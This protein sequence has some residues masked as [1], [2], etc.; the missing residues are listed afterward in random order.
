MRGFQILQLILNGWGYFMIDIP[1]EKV[2]FHGV[3]NVLVVLT[4]VNNI[5]NFQHSVL[6]TW[7]R[8]NIVH[9]KSQKLVFWYGWPKR[10]FY[11]LLKYLHLLILILSELIYQIIYLRLLLLKRRRNQQLKWLPTHHHSEMLQPFALLIIKISLLHQSH[12]L[13]PIKNLL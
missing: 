11:H 3:I 6:W 13:F 8:I 12:F 5:L 2:V 4:V 10:L 9:H 1:L 7:T